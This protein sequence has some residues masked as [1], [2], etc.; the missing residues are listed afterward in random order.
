VLSCIHYDAVDSHLPFAAIAFFLC[1]GR[2]L[3]GCGGAVAGDEGAGGSPGFDAGRD[4]KLIPYVPPT[5]G[6]NDVVKSDAYVER[7]PDAFVEEACPERA[8]PPPEI[9]CD[10]LSSGQCAEGS[11]CYPFPPQGRDPCNPGPYVMK[12][13]REGSGSQGA[14]CGSGSSCRGGYVCAVTGQGDEC[15]K[16]CRPGSIGACPEGM[17]CGRLDIPDLGGCI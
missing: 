4:V 14:A 10:P 6:S 5:D 11:A 16:L 2:A 7:T 15:L 9:H 3:G 17:V 8:P 1:A 13:A 12:C